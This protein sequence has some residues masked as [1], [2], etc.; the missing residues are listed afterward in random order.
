MPAVPLTSIR[1]HRVASSIT[2]VAAAVL[3][4]GCGGA[5]TGGDWRPT[6]DEDCPTWSSD[7][8][9]IAFGRHSSAG[10][11]A[12][13]GVHLYDVER[14]AVR[15]LTPDDLTVV[16]WPAHGRELIAFDGGELTFV[17]VR[18]GS[19]RPFLNL[20]ARLPEARDA[21]VL[22][23]PDLGSVLV[24]LQRPSTTNDPLD[25]RDEVWVV[26]VR[27]QAATLLSRP[28]ET[29]AG[30]ASW[31]PDGNW[32]AYD[33]DDRLYLVRPDGR[34]RRVVPSAK[35]PTGAV[36]S[37]DGRAL[38]YAAQGGVFRVELGSGRSRLLVPEL[39]Q[40]AAWSR[41]GRRLLVS[42]LG[43]VAVMDAATGSELTRLP[44]FGGTWPGTGVDCP[45]FSPDGS[46][47]A[48]LRSWPDSFGWGPSAVYLAP[49]SL[50]E[51]RSIDPVGR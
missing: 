38:A 17:S 2:A 18:D 42:S 3:T 49:A 28:N 27:T 21:F 4:A 44:E 34:S 30:D 39:D 14:D 40:P 7:G 16:A 6:F 11:D 45:A 9:T 50:R 48:F 33:D 24:S 46:R 26:D 35:S 8:S 12:P 5:G 41:D 43:G 15:R 37:P 10:S 25:Y 13:A 23:S 22:P 32:I 29:F 47:V 1:S 36:F 31:S 20:V 51:A 19:R